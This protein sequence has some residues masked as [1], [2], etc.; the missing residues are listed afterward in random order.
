[1]LMTRF[2]LD[3]NAM[4]DLQRTAVL[5]QLFAG[6]GERDDAWFGR[7]YDA[8]WYASMILVSDEAFSGPDG[9]P[10]LR[11]ELPRGGEAFDSQCL[12]NLAEPCLGRGCGAA[13][14]A[15]P[16]DPPEAA[17]FVVPFGVLDSMLRYDSPVGDPVDIAEWAL[18]PAPPPKRGFFG[19]GKAPPREVLLASP[20]PDYLPPYEARALHH[21]LTNRW[22]LEDPRVQLLIDA[23]NRPTRNLIIGRKRSTFADGGLLQDLMR[24]TSWYLPPGRGFA[25]MPE[26]WSLNQMTP[27][28]ELF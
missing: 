11:L 22:E 10:N 1:M 8:A 16:G 5:E 18:P 4:F 6:G 12:A 17:Q 3:R 21:Y 19:F 13:L 26:D 25:L 27:L 7:F 2:T 20:S 14:F 9:M 24:Y 28:R 23:Q 15:A